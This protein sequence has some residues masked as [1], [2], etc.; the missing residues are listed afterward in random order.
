MREEAAAVLV[1]ELRPGRAGRKVEVLKPVLEPLVAMRYH[2]HSPAEVHC[3]G[4]GCTQ[5]R[6]EGSGSGS[7][8][9]RK[10]FT[11]CSMMLSPPFQPGQSLQTF[12]AG[13]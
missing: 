11:V 9:A 3:V 10:L 8:A 1:L 5:G 13:F 6:I 2:L 12:P 7:C 4:V